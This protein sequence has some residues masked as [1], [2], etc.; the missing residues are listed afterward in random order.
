MDRRQFLS[1]SAPSSAGEGDAERQ[2]KEAALPIILAC[3]AFSSA[4]SP[5]N[6]PPTKFSHVGMMAAAAL[7]WATVAF[8]FATRRLPMP[9][10]E[11]WVVGVFF[12]GVILM[13][14]TAAATLQM[15]YW[16]L[17]VVGLDQLLVAGARP[18]AA[19]ALIAMVVAWLA[20][21]KGEAFARV[22]LYER[23][24]FSG[25]L[26]V[27]V[28]CACA[29]PPCRT[30]PVL[31]VIEWVSSVLIFLGD[32]HYTRGFA[33]GMRDREA[34]LESS[35]RAA[36][37]VGEQLAAYNTDAKACLA[38]AARAL[39]DGAEG[40]TLPPRL[41]AALGRL[42][43][44]LRRYHH[45]DPYLPQ[46]VIVFAKQDYEAEQ[47]SQTDASPRSSQ[48]SRQG[49]PSE[50]TV[51]TSGSSSSLHQAAKEAWACANEQDPC[52]AS[53]SS[54]L[55][56][57][58]AASLISSGRRRTFASLG[59]VS[60]ESTGGS[61]VL[62]GGG[63]PSGS[64]DGPDSVELDPRPLVRTPLA[65]PLPFAIKAEP[66]QKVASLIAVNRHGFLAAAAQVPLDAVSGWLATQIESFED[67]VAKRNGVL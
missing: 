29:K 38:D 47:E 13:D 19:Q 24:S 40:G 59:T 33:S 12:F 53:L 37:A 62:T 50:P 21:Q 60:R 23:T 14:W 25:E 55:S 8:V 15:R 58:L 46:S 44:N 11:A 61:K 65:A 3:T 45:C 30:G 31:A 48:Q 26:D 67:S 27:P 10:L 5:A 42:V 9:L 4:S 18:A 41:H 28:I 16:S 64:G 36:E 39:I 54:P 20:A 7:N 17:A 34:A 6:V 49:P 57:A 35:V 22:G 51:A 43:D 52:R 1:I 32:F 2:L 66:Q 56:P 63:A